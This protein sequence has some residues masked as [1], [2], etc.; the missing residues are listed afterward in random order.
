MD[1]EQWVDHPNITAIIWAGVPVQENGNALTDV[2]YGKVNPSGRLPYTVAGKLSDY[3]ALAVDGAHNDK[4]PINY[5]EQ[6]LV[7]YRHFDVKNITPHFKFGLGL[8][9]NVFTYSG[10]K[11]TRSIQPLVSTPAKN[12]IAGLTASGDGVRT[13][14]WLHSKFATVSFTLNNTGSVAGTKIPQLYLS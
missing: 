1:F 10:L 14:A 8:S 3:P 5:S 7:H 2:L 13:Q 12:W 9:Y 11:V 6:L 4:I